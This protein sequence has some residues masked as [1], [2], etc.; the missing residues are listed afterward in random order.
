M[1]ENILGKSIAFNVRKCC[2]SDQLQSLVSTPH[3]KFRRSLFYG[4][5]HSRTHEFKVNNRRNLRQNDRHHRQHKSYY[6]GQNKN[7]VNTTGTAGE[8]GW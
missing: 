1:R 8:F 6:G 3:K 7:R 5:S 4:V 2:T